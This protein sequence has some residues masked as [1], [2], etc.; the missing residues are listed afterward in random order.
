M[1]VKLHFCNH[2]D[3]AW[4]PSLFFCFATKVHYGK[5]SKKSKGKIGN[6]NLAP[7]NSKKITNFSYY[8]PGQPVWKFTMWE[9][10][11]N[12]AIQIFT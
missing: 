11:D 12:S 7:K 4:F 9:F 6:Q 2:I 3:S 8:R 1:N 10:Q 5:M